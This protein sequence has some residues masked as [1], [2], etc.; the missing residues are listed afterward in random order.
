M[1]HAAI[2]WLVLA[3]QVVVR[4]A[5]PIDPITGII[6]AFRTHP[7]VALAEGD[8]GNDQIRVFFRALTNDRRFPSTVND[9]LV[10]GANA[11]YQDVVDRYVNGDDVSEAEVRAAWENSTQTQVVLLAQHWAE[12][13]AGV[14]ALNARLPK[15]RRLR[16]LLGDPPI[17]W[18]LVHTH[19]DFMKVLALRDSFPAEVIRREVVAQHRHALILFGGMH[20]QRKQ[21]FSN[22]DMSNPIA[23]TLVSW[24]EAGPSPVKVFNVWTD[25]GSDLPALQPDIASWQPPAFALLRGT[26]LGRIDFKKF[27]S[28]PRQAPPMPMENQF[29]AILYLGTKITYREPSR[30]RCSDAA[31]M[32]AH[33]ARMAIDGL[34]QSEIDRIKRV[35]SNP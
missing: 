33:F 10:E 30:E 25:M 11:A 6:D 22:Y 28:T 2:A 9:I 1:R 3:A 4:P 16:I 34:P 12:F 26:V 29:D 31:Y 20:F 18:N 7:V 23:Q 5:V 8:H 14:R 15:E 24:L 13:P 19:D 32:Q 35:C 27:Y 21:I 17:D